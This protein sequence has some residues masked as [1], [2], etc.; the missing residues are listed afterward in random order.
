M[1]DQTIHSYLEDFHRDRRVMEVHFQREAER[2][3]K[4]AGSA[5]HALG[6]VLRGVLIALAG[7]NMDA[8]DD[9]RIQE[10][11]PHREWVS[12]PAT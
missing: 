5:P 9:P 4:S 10:C 6:L 12:G 8:C 11:S 2:E 1:D 3:S 7:M